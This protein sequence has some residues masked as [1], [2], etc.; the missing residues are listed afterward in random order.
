[1]GRRIAGRCPKIQGLIDLH[2]EHPYAFEAT[3][4]E[5]GLR[6]DDLG[7]DQLNWRD[8]YSIIH[9]LPANSPLNRARYPDSWFWYE[10]FYEVLA[11]IHDATQLR[12]AAGAN[13]EKVKK[14]ELPKPL[15]RPWNKVQKEEKLIGDKMPLDDMRAAL[16]W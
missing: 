13:R 2:R 5:R 14:T 15:V 3:L 8:L 6:W 11:G 10:P 9:T 7:T 12:A 4:I 16:G 1:M